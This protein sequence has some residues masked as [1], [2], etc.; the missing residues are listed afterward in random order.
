ALPLIQAMERLPFTYRL[1][2]YG[3]VPKELEEILL[4][5]I[6]RKRVVLHGVLF[7]KDL[8][9]F[10]RSLDLVVTTEKQAGWCNTAAEAFANGVPC[11]CS[12]PG[13]VDFARH[14]ENALVLEEVT[15][16]S[17]AGS[18]LALTKHPRW[19]AGLIRNALQTIRSFSYE[20]YARRILSRLDRPVA[21]QFFA[22]PESTHFGNHTPFF[23]ITDPGA[24]EGKRNRNKRGTAGS[25]Y[26]LP[27][28]DVGILNNE[29]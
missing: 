29:G 9:A 14:N 24:L 13:T 25:N 20:D 16:E 1:H 18:I 26:E 10:Y 12:K 15:G 2:L 28:E 8:A 5:L 11:I 7:Q 19:M 6:A 4:P 21:A 23:R 3:M 27:Q 17:I 22:C